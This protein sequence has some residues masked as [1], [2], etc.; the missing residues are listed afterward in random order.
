MLVVPRLGIGGAAARRRRRQKPSYVM[1]CDSACGAPST[2]KRQRARR[3]PARNARDAR[4]HRKMRPRR[5]G[6]AFQLNV[7]R[8][9]S[10]HVRRICFLCTQ[11]YSSNVSR[12]RSS[13]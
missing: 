9:H 13:A 10:I 2:G 5:P 4:W 7:V 12:C 8:K 11:F 1:A 3:T 6:T